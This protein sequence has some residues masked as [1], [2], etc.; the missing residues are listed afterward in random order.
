V[1]GTWETSLAKATRL[2]VFVD[3][4][5]HGCAVGVEEDLEVAITRVGACAVADEGIADGQRHL[6]ERRGGG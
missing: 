5:P 1:I 3:L 2:G 6:D 4:H